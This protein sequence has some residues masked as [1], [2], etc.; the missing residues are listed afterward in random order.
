MFS[1]IFRRKGNRDGSTLILVLIVFTVLMLLG[2]AALTASTVATKVTASTA[3]KQQAD[4]IAQSA[5]KSAVSYILKNPAIQTTISSLAIKGILGGNATF[6]TQGGVTSTIVVKAISATT[7]SVTATTPTVNGVTGTAVAYI[8][9]NGGGTVVNPFNNLFYSTSTSTLDFTSN[10]TINGSIYTAG[11]FDLDNSAALNG[12]IYAAGGFIG[13]NGGALVNGDVYTD[14]DATFQS[15]AVVNGNMICGGNAIFNNWS[16]YINKNLTAGKSYTPN[17]S[18]NHVKGIAIT[19]QTVPKLNINFSYDAN[20]QVM[21]DLTSYFNGINF[22]NAYDISG[23]TTIG[24]GDTSKSN[25]YT[26]GYLNSYT[27]GGCTVT[28]DTSKTNVCM[29]VDASLY[30]QVTNE[31][32]AN[33]VMPTVNL[34]NIKIQ[35]TGP[36]NFYI[37]LVGNTQ[38][39]LSGGSPGPIICMQNPNY[40]LNTTNGKPTIYIVGTGS[41]RIELQSAEIDGYIYL[42]NGSFSASGG[43]G[44]KGYGVFGSII[45][46]SVDTSGS[47]GTWQQYTP[48]LT[49]TPFNPLKNIG[50]YTLPGTGGTALWSL[51]GWSQ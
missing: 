47:S 18:N 23:N 33:K 30:D 13:G 7:F 16:A 24:S 17:D 21:K 12:N 42:P 48:D 31:T 3:A 26:S 41:Q 32:I 44:P 43:A 20:S 11:V 29:K 28:V 50:T 36:N 25:Y 38:F 10:T 22:T 35:V 37:Y 39:E 5:A 45:T 49:L 8:A 27:S 2:M 9:K 19:N 1:K 46:G 15:S 4:F 51:S 14:N 40:N 6:T 34:G